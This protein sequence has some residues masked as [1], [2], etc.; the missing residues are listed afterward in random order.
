MLKYTYVYGYYGG[1]RPGAERTLF[2]H[3]QTQLE[4]ST[5]H[6]AEL[7][8]QPPDKMQRAEVSKAARHTR[9]L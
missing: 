8:E 3:L 5:E 7:T 1:A 9:W 2:E 6:L 4:G